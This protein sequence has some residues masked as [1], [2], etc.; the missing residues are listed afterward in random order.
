V[1]QVDS[2]LD[3]YG[4]QESGSSGGELEAG[5][6]NA[7][8]IEFDD[9]VEGAVSGFTPNAYELEVAADSVIRAE[10]RRRAG[11]FEPLIDLYSPFLAG[12]RLFTPDASEWT[13]LEAS[14]EWSIRDAG[15]YLVV[16]KAGDVSEQGL[17]VL[18]VRCVEGGCL[19]AETDEG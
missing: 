5:D 8:A 12:Y 16:V 19:A 7:V 11:T 2:I 13:E 14:V 3:P 17:F 6:G 18:R 4:G 1:G 15:T 9:S 10:F